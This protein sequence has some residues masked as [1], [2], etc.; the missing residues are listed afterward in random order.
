MDLIRGALERA[1]AEGGGSPPDEEY[2]KRHSYMRYNRSI[3]NLLPWIGRHLDLASSD[4]IEVGCGTG[5]TLVG[6]AMN[7]RHAHGYDIDPIVLETCS[8]RARAFGLDN[9]SLHLS[10]PDQIQ[11]EMARQHPQGVDAILL[12]AVLE[13]LTP[14]ERLEAI[15]NTWDLVRPNGLLIVIEAPNRFNYFDWHSTQLPFFHQLPKELQRLYFDRSPR[16]PYVTAMSQALASG[17]ETALD[18]ALT[19]FGQSLSYH[20]FELTLGPLDGLVVDDG[21]HPLVDRVFTR[22]ELIGEDALRRF[23]VDWEIP[24]PRGFDRANIN[25]ILRRPGG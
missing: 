5:S 4:V 1:S 17:G 8:A 22:N 11:S 19:R 3:G 13:H 7:A 20:E 10:P 23:I 2:L 16:A 9:V 21:D 18:E 15:A 6:L 14:S 25:V 24:V 12:Y